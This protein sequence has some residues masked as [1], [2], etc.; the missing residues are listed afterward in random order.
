MSRPAILA[1]M[2]L[3]SACGSPDAVLV[4]SAGAAS[5]STAAAPRPTPNQDVETPTGA[6]RIR[7]DASRTK[8]SLECVDA[9]SSDA[10]GERIWGYDEV[11]ASGRGAS[12][13]TDGTRLYA[14]WYPVAGPG[15]ELVAYE[16]KSGA[17]AWRNQLVGVGE[18]PIPEGAYT[19][20]VELRL[21]SGRLRVLGWELA[22]RYIE[23][24]DPANG[25]TLSSS[26]YDHDALL[27]RTPPTVGAGTPTAP[28]TPGKSDGIA[29]V[30]AGESPRRDRDVSVTTP[31]GT[32]CSFALDQGTSRTHLACATDGARI[33][34]VDLANQFVPGG[35]LATD[36]E[37]LFVVDYCAISSGASVTAYDVAR[38]RFLWTRAL[39]AL[40]P[41][42]HS[43]YYNDVDVRVD[44]SLG[45]NGAVVVS[46]WEAY[47]KYVEVLDPATGVDLGNRKEPR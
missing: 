9:S 16:L 38:G 6:C 2:A 8:V 15:C 21:V 47:G 42:S 14:A 35:A 17:I 4:P 30:F 23:E 32:T 18:T 25:V 46:G 26:T 11:S 29:F 31:T 36:G 10:V 39:Y 5:S 45:Q 7:S 44:G 40:G 24:V 43:E 27:A 22:G 12:I 33:W 34:G 28:P 13:V 1:S 19:N 41:V 20:A 3:A 37:R